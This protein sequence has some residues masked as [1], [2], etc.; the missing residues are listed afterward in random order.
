MIKKLFSVF[1]LIIIL[2]NLVYGF[3]VQGQF[4]I[5]PEKTNGAPGG[6]G[7]G[8]DSGGGAVKPASEENKSC[9]EVWVCIEWG[10]CI[11]GIQ[12]RT[13]T[14]VNYCREDYKKI[15]TRLCY[16]PEQEKPSSKK[17]EPGFLFKPFLFNLPPWALLLILSIITGIIVIIRLMKRKVKR[18]SRKKRR[19]KSKKNEKAKQK[20]EE[21]SGEKKKE[22]K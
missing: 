21:K 12:N 10:E 15:E 18:K 14:D 13:C 1:L 2:A 7:G 6:D 16:L 22:E 20:P 19:K 3:E 8:G 9:S 11:K 5:L 4:E 17:P